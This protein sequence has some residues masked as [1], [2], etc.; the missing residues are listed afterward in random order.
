[1]VSHEAEDYEEVV[2]VIFDKM[3]KMKCKPKVEKVWVDFE[4][5]ECEPFRRR[6]IIICRCFFHWSQAQWRRFGN[7]GLAKYYLKGKYHIPWVRKFFTM[8]LT[9]PFFKPK[10]ISTDCFTTL[11]HLLKMEETELPAPVFRMLT[12]FLISYYSDY[13]LASSPYGPPS[14]WS[15]FMRLH[16]R[17]N[18][19]VEGYH[20]Y[21]NRLIGTKPRFFDFIEKLRDHMRSISKGIM[22]FKMGEKVTWNIHPYQRKRDEKISKILVLYHTGENSVQATMDALILHMI[23]FESAMEDPR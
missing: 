11:H 10:D 13:V 14:E 12:K 1:M 22:F 18:N 21:L 8:F 15:V 20:S 6:N 3:E 5:A 19:N 23:H 9:M 4:S 17:T 16:A 2:K 7:L